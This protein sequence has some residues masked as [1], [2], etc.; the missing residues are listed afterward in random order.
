MERTDSMT[1]LAWNYMLEKGVWHTFT[2]DHSRALVTNQGQQDN[3]STHRDGRN[4]QLV[5]H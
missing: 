2:N 3:R 1:F 4:A 5:H